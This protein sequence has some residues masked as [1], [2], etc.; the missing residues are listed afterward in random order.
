MNNRKKFRKKVSIEETRMKVISD[1][2][3]EK[4]KLIN[5]IK[6]QR[7]DLKE[8][9]NQNPLFA[10]TLRPYKIKTNNST[11]PEIIQKMINGSNVAD[12]GPTATLA[13]TIAEISLEYLIKNNSDYS[14]LDNGGDIAFINNNLDK[15]VIFGIYAGNS[16]ISGKIGLEFKPK[17]NQP[18][19]V[20]TSS[21][22]V[23][24]SISYGRS[25]CVTVIS[26]Q[27]SIADGLST[28]IGNRV[29]GKL[30]SE[31]VENGLAY[32]EKFE[33]HFMGALIIV[34]ESIGTIG[35]L[36]KIVET[37]D[38]FILNNFDGK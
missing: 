38:K 28:S 35:D 2:D 22:S 27:T 12:V 36:P 20:C 17:K 26:N 30:D 23:G 5:F 8:Y 32:A 1:I 25:D 33:N 19:G 37:D 4:F 21:G 14:I 31:A 18:L 7:N 3:I 13:G 34:G 6:K 10:K 9:I 29:N 15:K 11:N 16:P 24:Y